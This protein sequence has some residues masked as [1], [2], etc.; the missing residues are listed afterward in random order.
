MKRKAL[1]PLERIMGDPFT[2]EISWLTHEREQLHTR[3]MKSEENQFSAFRGASKN[4]FLS[5]TRHK[6]VARHLAWHAAISRRK[7]LEGA[8]RA[9]VIGGA[10]GSGLLRPLSASAAPGIGNVLPTPTT[11]EVLGSELHVQ[12]P[13]FTGVDTDPATVN[14]FRGASGIA[15]INT[16]ATRRH[17]RTGLVQKDL[18]SSDNHMTFLQGVYRGRDGHVRGATF[19]LV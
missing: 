7:F 2:V 11:L 12:A 17:R 10:L 13:P 18:D 14:N 4:K 9:S 8:V 15:L 5:V 19:A 6:P 3:R 1:D 16:T